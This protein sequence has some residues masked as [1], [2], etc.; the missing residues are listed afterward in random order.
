MFGNFYKIDKNI[1]VPASAGGNG[2]GPGA[3]TSTIEMLHPGE[4]FFVPKLTKQRSGSATAKQLSS[5]ATHVRKK[6]PDR[7][8]TVRTVKENRQE[9]ARL[10][11]VS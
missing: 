5:A 11:R 4:S 10:W 7:R 3:T 1:P 2:R 9:G 6:H 8:F